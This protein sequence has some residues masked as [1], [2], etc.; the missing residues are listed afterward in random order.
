MS[1]ETHIAG[2]EDALI[3]GLHFGNRSTASY[4][5]ERRSSTFAPQTSADITPAGSRLLCFAL[6]DQSGFLDGATVRLAFKLN[7]L[8]G[9]V[10]HPLG[11]SPI[12][13]FR[14]LRVIANGSSVIEDIE[15]LSRVS[16]LLSLLKPSTQ[17]YNDCTASW[18][19]AAT[20]YDLE[21]P[22]LVASIP[23]D[24]SRYVL[25]QL[26]SSFL[27]Q[28]KAIPLSMVPLV[29]ELEL[30]DADAAFSGTGNL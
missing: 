11:D 17:R 18:G 13:L 3:D 29:L 10:L 14:R 24:A 16:Q 4:I 6:S 7:S 26:P 30:G 25:C 19:G 1:L 2:A 20:G 21:N 23:A 22:E 5:T 15:D 28:G 27:N 12:S 9:T 8:A